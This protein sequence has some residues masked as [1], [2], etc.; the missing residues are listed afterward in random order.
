[1][2]RYGCK[3]WYK[4]THYYH[5]Y[6]YPYLSIIVIHVATSAWCSRSAERELRTYCPDYWK[7]FVCWAKERKYMKSFL[8]FAKQILNKFCILDFFR[9]LKFKVY[10]IIILPVVLYSC[11]TF[12]LSIRKQSRLR[13]GYVKI[14]SWGEY[15]DPRRMKIG[16]EKAPQWRISFVPF[17]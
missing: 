7:S 2:W 1:M 13:V 11:E 10:K 15:L 4:Y 9:N 3:R 6:N 14:G 17:P 8:R 16:V 5:V 12:F